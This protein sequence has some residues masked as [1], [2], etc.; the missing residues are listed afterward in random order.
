MTDKQLLQLTKVELVKMLRELQQDNERLQD[1]LLDTQHELAI[2]LDK[3][4][5]TNQTTGLLQHIKSEY[6]SSNLYAFKGRDSN[7]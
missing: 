4:M 6:Q 5:S 2:E 3:S 1:E 7:C